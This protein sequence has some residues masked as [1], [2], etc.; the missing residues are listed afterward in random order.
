MIFSTIFYEPF[1]ICDAVDSLPWAYHRDNRRYQKR[2]HGTWFARSSGNLLLGSDRMHLH[3][4][5]FFVS[6]LKHIKLFRR[7]LFSWLAKSK[8]IIGC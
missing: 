2:V 5:Y 1:H 6:Q 7:I 4:M 8:E 3:P